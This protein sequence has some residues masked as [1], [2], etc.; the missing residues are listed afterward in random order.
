MIYIVDTF[1]ELTPTRLGLIA[2]GRSVVEIASKRSLSEIAPNTEAADI[3]ISIYHFVAQRLEGH[4]NVPV[5]LVE[6]EEG[7]DDGIYY[8]SIVLHVTGEQPTHQQLLGL[9]E[10]QVLEQRRSGVTARQAFDRLQ[11]VRKAVASK[12]TRQLLLL[13]RCAAPAQ[14]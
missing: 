14:R 9:V 13:W 12:L 3:E 8:H 1:M 11:R 5:W 6:I 10:M 4:E 7:A 2:K